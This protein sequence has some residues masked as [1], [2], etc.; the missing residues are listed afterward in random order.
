MH[1]MAGAGESDAQ[2]ATSTLVGVG[3]LKRERR[4]KKQGVKSGG[5]A[6]AGTDA[7]EAEVPRVA[8][9]SR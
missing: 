8:R 9:D 6:C 2:R 4:A 3:A 7:A 1:Y 5:A